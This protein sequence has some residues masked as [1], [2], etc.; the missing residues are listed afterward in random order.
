M[1]KFDGKVNLHLAKEDIFLELLG[2][3]KGC[4]VPLANM[5]NSEKKVNLVLDLN[6]MGAET[7]HQCSHATRNH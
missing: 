4:V 7:V 3:K 1:L 2:L 5:N 6:F